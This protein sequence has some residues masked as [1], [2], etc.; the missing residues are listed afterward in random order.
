M[1]NMVAE[2]KLLKVELAI[3]MKAKEAAGAT[4]DVDVGP[5]AK[6]SA[7]FHV[8]P[9][10]G[11]MEAAVLAAFEQKQDA[12]LTA[13]LSICKKFDD[14]GAGSALDGG[15]T[16]KAKEGKALSDLLSRVASMKVPIYYKPYPEAF[17]LHVHRALEYCDLKD[18]SHGI[19]SLHLQNEVRKDE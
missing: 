13:L 16:G 12:T 14:E 15:K 4:I 3:A 10:P 18:H 9:L 11:Q 1:A 2:C 17:G 19:V 7:P 5:S 6:E 8:Q